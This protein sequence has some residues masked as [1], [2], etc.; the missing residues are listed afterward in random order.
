M[1]QL[2]SRE[3][4][5]S[6]WLE[7]REISNF[8]GW[9]ATNVAA[10][11]RV[12]RGCVSLERG[13]EEKLSRLSYWA[14]VLSGRQNSRLF[15]LAGDVSCLEVILFSAWRMQPDTLFYRYAY[16]VLL[17][18]AILSWCPSVASDRY[19]TPMPKMKSPPNSERVKLYDK[20]SKGYIY[21]CRREVPYEASFRKSER[22]CAGITCTPANSKMKRCN[23]SCKCMSKD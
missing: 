5:S 15:L 18:Q 23:F 21:C 7:V 16:S 4:L 11:R 8:A 1:R 22:V 6:N 3:F 14:R 12:P 10:G 17:W 2:S 9:A 19:Q 13:P 20:S